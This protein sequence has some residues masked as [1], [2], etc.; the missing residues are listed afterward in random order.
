MHRALPYTLLFLIVVLLQIY[1]FNN[2]SIGSWF[3]PLVYLTFLVLLPLETPPIVMLLLGLVTGMVM[4]AT[5]GISGI[6]TLA[7]L[8]VAFLRPKLI[9]LLSARD[10]MRDDGVPSPER[11][12]KALFWSY[13]VVMILLHHTLFFTLEALSWH[14]LLRT[15]L[16]IVLSSAGTL[17]FISIAT[18]LFTAKVTSNSNLR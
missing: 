16:R 14:H 15:L 5:M 8:P 17:G 12:G 1:L 2:L 6:N 18:R 11:M 13:V 7:T 4:D 3:S 10:D 9:H